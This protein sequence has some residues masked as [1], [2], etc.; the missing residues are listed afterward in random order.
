MSRELERTDRLP[1]EKD[2]SNVISNIDATGTDNLF[3][4][5]SKPGFKNMLSFDSEES[6]DPFQEVKFDKHGA[7]KNQKIVGME[8]ARSIRKEPTIRSSLGM[9]M[10]SN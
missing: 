8:N 10:I 2:K 5:P 9:S 6:L 7:G 4:Q 1:K 3:E